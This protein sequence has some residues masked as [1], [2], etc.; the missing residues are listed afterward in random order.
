[1]GES[2]GGEAEEMKSVVDD[3]MVPQMLGEEP[4]SKT[5][6]KDIAEVKPPL[7]E[8][9]ATLHVAAL[10]ASVA[11]LPSNKALTPRRE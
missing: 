2:D 1:M 9:A 7:V 8:V 3:L 10:V 5:K 6:K 11:E 4:S